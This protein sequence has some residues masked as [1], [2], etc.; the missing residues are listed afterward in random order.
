MPRLL[1]KI[2]S[3]RYQQVSLDQYLRRSEVT[4][5]DV[6]GILNEQIE[7]REVTTQVEIEI[8]YSGYIDREMGIVNRMKQYEDKKIPEGLIFKEVRGLRREAVEKF[9]HIRPVSLGQAARIS[10]IT[11]CD[12]SLLAVYLEKLR[13]SA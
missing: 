2:K 7:D 9:D 12:I 10:G 11:P 13:R 4:M 6:L 3:Q 8:K 1:E 5:N